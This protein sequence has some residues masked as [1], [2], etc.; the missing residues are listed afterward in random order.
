MLL[1]RIGDFRIEDG[2]T[3]IPGKPLKVTTTV[4]MGAFLIWQKNT[5]T[6]T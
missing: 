5:H 3:Q 6:Y 4:T 2:V 1:L